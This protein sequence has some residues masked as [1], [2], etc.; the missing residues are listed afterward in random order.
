[1]GDFHGPGLEEACAG[2]NAKALYDPPS[3]VVHSP[4]SVGQPV[5]MK[6]CHSQDCY[7]LWQKGEFYCWPCSNHMSA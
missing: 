5:P 7:L 1:M 3:Y 6:G 4:L 2:Q